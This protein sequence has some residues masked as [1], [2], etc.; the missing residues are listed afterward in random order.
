ML[1]FLALGYASPCN[2]NDC[3]GTYCYMMCLLLNGQE[4]RAKSLWQNKYKGDSV[5]WN[6]A[7][8]LIAKKKKPEPMFAKLVN[9]D[10]SDY[11]FI[12]IYYVY[13]SSSEN[14]AKKNLSR[15][16]DILNNSKCDERAFHAIHLYLDDFWY[17]WDGYDQE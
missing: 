9:E 7:N 16:F 8:D 2:P 12:P 3:G 13:Y 1:F 4:N 14:E 6:M 5:A 17:K 11:A 10:C 15:Y